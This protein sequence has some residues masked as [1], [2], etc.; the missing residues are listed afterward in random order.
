[1]CQ[2]FWVGGIERLTRNV[3]VSGRVHFG[4]EIAQPH[5]DPKVR[6]TAAERAVAAAGIERNSRRPSCVNPS[7]TLATRS[8]GVG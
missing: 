6:Q 3:A 7:G 1:M 2:M 5:V 4:V 8:D